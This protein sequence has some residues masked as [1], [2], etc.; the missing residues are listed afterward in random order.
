[1]DQWGK[2]YV[3]YMLS[4]LKLYDIEQIT[5][6]IGFTKMFKLIQD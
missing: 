4:K 2:S 3:V 1:M 5:Y 6:L